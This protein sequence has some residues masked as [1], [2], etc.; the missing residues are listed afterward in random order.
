MA[1][2]E[3][4]GWKVRAQQLQQ[5]RKARLQVSFSFSLLFSFEIS[6]LIILINK[7]QTKMYAVPIEEC[8][9]R[10][11][12]SDAPRHIPWLVYDILTYIRKDY[13]KV[14]GLFRLAGEKLTTDEW[15]KKIDQGY[16]NYLI[17]FFQKNIVFCLIHSLGWKTHYK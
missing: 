2:G 3:T 12:R 17:F 7:S 10:P 8:V 4:K 16:F 15:K 9:N 13:M 1:E 11:N 5:Q 6:Y 14:V